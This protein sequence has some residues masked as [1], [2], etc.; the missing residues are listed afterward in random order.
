MA[1]TKEELEAEELEKAEGTGVSEDVLMKAIEKVEDLSKSI[2]EGKETGKV[3]K[4]FAAQA[5]EASDEIKKGV[6]VSD[7]LEHFVSE[8]G[9][10]MDGLSTKITK[11]IELNHE[12]LTG[13]TDV[14]KSFGAEITS[15]KEQVAAFGDAPATGAKAI[16]KG[17]QR[18]EEESVELTKSQIVDK[19]GDMIQKGIA[20]TSDMLYF[21][22]T[23][24]LR[25]ELAAKMK[26]V[27]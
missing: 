10:Y 20:R 1:K 17:I 13:L 18:F 14:I 27:K 8:T 12:L 26:E 15:L 5:T 23:G 25:P 19:L 6:E 16:R 2:T 24:R 11:S 7:F 9:D 21:E 4:S 3:E 22:T